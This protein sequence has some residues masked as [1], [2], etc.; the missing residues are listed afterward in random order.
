MDIEYV[1]ITSWRSTKD[2][3]R[4][5]RRL[6]VRTLRSEGVRTRL[7]VGRLRKGIP[8]VEVQVHV[9]DLKKARVVIAGQES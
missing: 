7:H 3:I 5:M 4:A 6:Y 2:N 9:D 1:A 8:V